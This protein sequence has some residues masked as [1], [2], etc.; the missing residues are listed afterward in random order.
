MIVALAGAGLLLAAAAGLYWK[1]RLEG[2]ARERPKVEVALE[3]AAISG[4]QTQGELASAQ[5]VEVVVRQRE[6]AARSVA[7]I[8]EDALKSEDADAPLDPARAERLRLS[9]ERLCNAGPALAGCA[10]D[11]D[12]HGGE[13]PV[14]DLSPSGGADRG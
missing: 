13:T 8:T 5:R 7:Q 12:A 1:G 10:A 9:D 6:A 4:L 3:R 2:A 14:R 11:R